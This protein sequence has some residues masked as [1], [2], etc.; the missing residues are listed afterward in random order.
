[1]LSDKPSLMFRSVTVSH[2]GKTK[3]QSVNS[4]EIRQG[5]RLSK[6]VASEIAK[7]K[8]ESI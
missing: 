6:R 1:M 4:A 3:L 8:Y 5:S 2:Q 7:I